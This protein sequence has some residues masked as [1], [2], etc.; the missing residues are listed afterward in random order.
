MSPLVPLIAGFA[1]LAAG[2]LV[3]RSYG[4][5]FRVGRLLASAPAVSI[6][7]ARALAAGRPRYV[8]VQ[9]RIDSETEFED[10]AHRP[11][12]F[13]RTRLQVREGTGWRDLDDH[14]ER[15]PF[16]IREGL[17]SIAVDDAALDTGLVV[18]VREA[19]GIAADI[20]DR[21]PAGTPPEA[22]ARLLVEQISSVE[23]AI[24]V[25]VAMLGALGEAT[26]SAGLGRPLI[27]TTLERSEAMRVLA[28]GDPRRPMVAVV[29]LIGGLA[30][31]GVGLAWVLVGALS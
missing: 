26:I 18:I 27:L 29:S 19:E 16:E 10:A 11:L 15:V 1:A 6:A 7:E 20:V 28:N 31:L 8:R 24:V 9:G 5:N 3:L 21:L 2:V 22:S 17:D 25:G 13:R 30:L 23:Q 14:R 12:V 4:S